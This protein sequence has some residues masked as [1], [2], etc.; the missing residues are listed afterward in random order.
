MTT[1]TMTSLLLRS[2][3]SFSFVV[4]VT[5]A[6]TASFAEKPEW[7]GKGKEG[8]EGKGG[9]QQ[10]HQPQE[11]PHKNFQFDSNS[12]R[13]NQGPGVN[14]T[15]NGNGNGNGNA[16]RAGSVKV[17]GYFGDQQRVVVRN[18]YGSEYKAGRCPPGLAKKNN[19]CMPPGQA[20][21][22]TVGQRLPSNVVYY[23]VP[24]NVVY[25]LGAPP[26]GYRYV[27]VA[28]DILLLAIGTSM[29]VDA[30]RNLSGY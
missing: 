26:S 13:I 4:A 8:K 25:Q 24:Q 3:R 19:G 30:I 1:K 2:S 27:R 22:Y 21:K 20:K 9:Q 14:K 16:K 7:A 5:L 12:Q 6:C 18:Y 28:S 15:G 29:V 17:G 23:A 11:Q 10:Q